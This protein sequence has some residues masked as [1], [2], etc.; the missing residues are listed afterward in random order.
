[1]S[2]KTPMTIDLVDEDGKVRMAGCTLWVGRYDCPGNIAVMAM[3][4]DGELWGMITVNPPEK[5]EDD[6]LCIKD[7][8]EGRG[9]VR[10]MH[11]AGLVLEP[12]RMIP[13]GFVELSVCRL[14]EKGKAWI[15]A[16]LANENDE[17]EVQQC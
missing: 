12:E 16:A 17:Q 13:S 15:D 7:Y 2:E 9:N 4:P 3:C 6:V 1:M 8:S 14:S 11:E 10:S 5:L